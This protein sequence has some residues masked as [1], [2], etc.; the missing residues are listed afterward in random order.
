MIDK[1]LWTSRGCCNL[2]L[3]LLRMLMLLL[4]LGSPIL[5]LLLVVVVESILLHR[6]MKLLSTRILLKLSLFRPTFLAL[7]LTSE[8]QTNLV[9]KVKL[10]LKPH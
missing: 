6:W 9:L 8:T 2:S 1:A 3:L 10:S 4:L 7:L 5:V